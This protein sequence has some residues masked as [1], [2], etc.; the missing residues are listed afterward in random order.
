L[1]TKVSLLQAKFILVLMGFLS[2]FLAIKV[3]SIVQ[4]LLMALTFFS[5][6]FILP[7]LAGLTGFRNKRIRS[8]LAMVLGGLVALAGRITVI[9]GNGLVG[10]V[11][12]FSAFILNGLLLFPGGKWIKV[13]EKNR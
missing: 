5:G 9:S 3:T 13:S 7:V 1:D 11:L 8:N 12:I 4:S 2:I 6:A 10:N